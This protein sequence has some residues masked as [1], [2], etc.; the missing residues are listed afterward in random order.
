MLNLN[1]DIMR[2]IISYLGC[3]QFKNNDI[4]TKLFVLNKDFNIKL[5]T[6]VCCKINKYKKLRVCIFHQKPQD[7]NMNYVI[8][9]LNEA[10][11]YKKKFG[12]VGKIELENENQ[13]RLA[14]PY[15]YQLGSIIERD[16]KGLSIYY[17]WPLHF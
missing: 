13:I 3:L 15:L 12:F 1:E 16:N 14:N 8:N 9:K 5:K 4:Q 17:D 11:Y 7:Y 2:I 10:T 6:L